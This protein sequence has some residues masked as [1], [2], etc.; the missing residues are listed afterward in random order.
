MS[1]NC[2]RYISIRRYSDTFKVYLFVCFFVCVIC[3]YGGG[4]L[5]AP[6]HV[7]VEARGQQWL[8]SSVALSL[9]FSETGF[10][11]ELEIHQLTR[12]AGQCI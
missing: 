8:S 6:L 10:L 9:F 5:H 7:C 4:G 3:V 1:S 11:M 12:L 2:S